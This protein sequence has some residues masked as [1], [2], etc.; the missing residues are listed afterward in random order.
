MVKQ[1]HG[2]S[3]AD[4]VDNTQWNIHLYIDQTSMYTLFENS[5]RSAQAFLYVNRAPEQQ[6]F[7]TEPADAGI[8]KPRRCITF[9]F[10]ADFRDNRG[11]CE[12]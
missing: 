10:F 6:L 8:E 11:K 4:H 9:A 7:T 5:P 1:R 12:K 3:N 2:S